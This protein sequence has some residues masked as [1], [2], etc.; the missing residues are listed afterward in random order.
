MLTLL[1]STDIDH[2]KRAASESIAQEL[3]ERIKVEQDT[4]VDS[5]PLGGS[6]ST[7]VQHSPLLALAG[8]RLPR[9]ACSVM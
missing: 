2:R 3:E 9:H 8:D 1:H 6:P 7:I 4:V 5:T